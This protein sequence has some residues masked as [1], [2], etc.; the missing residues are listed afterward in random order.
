VLDDL[1]AGSAETVHALVRNMIQDITA[2]TVA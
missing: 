1:T 2:L